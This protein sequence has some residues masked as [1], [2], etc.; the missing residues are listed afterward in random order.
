MKDKFMKSF[1]RRSK[2]SIHFNMQDNLTNVL[3]SIGN[4]DSISEQIIIE[5]DDDIINTEMIAPRLSEK[6][7]SHLI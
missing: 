1:N 7:F 6:T 3:S 5:E 2:V 4:K